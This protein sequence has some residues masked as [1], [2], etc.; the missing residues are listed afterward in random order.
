[1]TSK[2]PEQ[3][4]QERQRVLDAAINQTCQNITCP[5]CQ[6]R[7]WHAEEVYLLPVHPLVKFRSASP[8]L[9]VLPARCKECG[10]LLFFSADALG[11]IPEQFGIIG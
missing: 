5:G 2:P 8:G 10:Y 11:V 7:D 9:N 6:K 4:E 3:R 1:M